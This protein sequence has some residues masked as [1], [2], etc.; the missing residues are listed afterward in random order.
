VRAS[1][2]GKTRTIFA[3]SD[4]GHS[5]F[6]GAAMWNF[7]RCWSLS[8]MLAVALACLSLNAG[9]RADD[10]PKIEI[11]PQLAHAIW[12]RSVAFS[13]DGAQ[14]LS[15]SEDKPLKL[16]ETATGR[17]IRTFEGHSAWVDSVAFAPDGARVLSGSTDKTLKLWETASG[18]LIIQHRSH[19]HGA[20]WIG[21]LCH[22][23]PLKTRRRPTGLERRLRVIAADVAKAGA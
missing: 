16:W 18:R 13:P 21:L 15:G 6:G 3:P 8:E 20:G 9:V 19:Q 4:T 7:R 12:V 11:V 2:L 10:E 1:N 23:E 22:G 17:L 14:V 5:Y